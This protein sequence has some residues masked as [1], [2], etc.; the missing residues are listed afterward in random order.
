MSLK[1]FHIF[2]VA[3]TFLLSIM[4]AWWFV[5]GLEASALIRWSGAV[6]C[7]IFGGLLVVYGARFLKKFKDLGFM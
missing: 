3:A 5:E 2:F 6:I 7:L 4:V 1:S